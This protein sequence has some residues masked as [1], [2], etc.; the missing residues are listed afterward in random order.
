[1]MAGRYARLLRAMVLAIPIVSGCAAAPEPQQP[2]GPLVRILVSQS[3]HWPARAMEEQLAN[4]R[5]RFNACGVGLDFVHNTA[6]E[7]RGGRDD[8]TLRLLFVP[9]L[10]MVG[11]EPIVGRAFNLSHPK[12]AEIA[13]MTPDGAAADLKQ[14]V[15]HEL[16]HLFGLGHV[17]RGRINLMAPNG[18]EFCRFTRAQCNVLQAKAREM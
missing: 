5:K 10:D 12:R 17:S 4:A 1:M 6:A 7:P 9:S 18:C 8:A 15:A 16:G 11:G 3:K 2:S 13:W 14:T